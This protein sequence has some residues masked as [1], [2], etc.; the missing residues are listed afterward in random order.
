MLRHRPMPGEPEPKQ[1]PN[2]LRRTMPFN[3]LLQRIVHASLPSFTGSLEVRDN[4]RADWRLQ[5]KLVCCW[6][7]SGYYADFMIRRATTSC[8][9]STT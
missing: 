9:F 3:I 1:G 4:F 6:S 7:W 2:A 5:F 8:V